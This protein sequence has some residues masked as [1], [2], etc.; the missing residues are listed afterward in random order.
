MKFKL[1][2]VF[3]LCRNAFSGLVFIGRTVVGMGFQEFGFSVERLYRHPS[4]VA[5]LA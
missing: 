3:G 1:E 5:T 2:V 4:P